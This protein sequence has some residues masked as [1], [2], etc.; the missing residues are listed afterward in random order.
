MITALS[1]PDTL[2]DLWMVKIMLAPAYRAVG[3]L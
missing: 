2:T 3:T 1:F